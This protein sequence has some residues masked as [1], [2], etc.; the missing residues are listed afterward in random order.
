[1]LDAEILIEDLAFGGDGVGRLDGKAIFI[2]GAIPGETVRIRIIKDKGSYARGEILKIL[3]PSPLRRSPPCPW[4][5]KCGGCSYQHLEYSAQLEFKEAQVRALMA[6]LGGMADVPVHP[7]APSPTEFAYRNRITVHTRH[8]RTGFHNRGGHRIVEIEECLLAPEELNLA[9]RKWKTRAPSTSVRTLRLP[10]QAAVFHQVN[11]PVAREV[12][13]TVVKAF[14]SKCARFGDAYCGAG[15]FLH[16][17]RDHYAEGWGIEIDPHAIAL[18]QSQGVSGTRLVEG[19]VEEILADQL[20]REPPDVLMV[21]PPSP[22]L[23]DAVVAAILAQ[24][25]AHLF[26]LSCNP[27]TQA[28]DLAKLHERFEVRWLQPFDMF[29]Q[30]ASIEVLA[31]LQRRPTTNRAPV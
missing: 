16:G 31:A 29:P 4:F 24:P 21:D 17:L 8:G 19:A 28:R 9:F 18:A 14:P 3:R 26:Y 11:P 30:T 2:P 13:Q 12:L 6:R 20:D 5:L 22:G 25:P 7:I 15:F 1:M 27:G 10:G 23:H